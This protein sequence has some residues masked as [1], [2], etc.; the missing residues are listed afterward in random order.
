[1]GW[2]GLRVRVR[3]RVGKRGG[4]GKAPGGA[5]RAFFLLSARPSG[6]FM[7]LM[8]TCGAGGIGPVRRAEGRGKGGG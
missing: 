2:E 7:I 6:S 5:R 4:E 1:M 3:E 8:A